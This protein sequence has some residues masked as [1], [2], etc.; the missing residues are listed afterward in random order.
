M[1][2]TKEPQPID[3]EACDEF[4]KDFIEKHTATGPWFRSA[5][6]QLSE[7]YLALKSERDKLQAFKDFVHRRLD[8][9]GV[10]AN[11]EPPKHALEGCRIGDRLDWIVEKVERCED[12]L[13]RTWAGTLEDR[14][15]A[16]HESSDEARAIAARRQ[17]KE[18]K[19]NG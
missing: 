13:V 16:A 2:P 1:K 19:A 8:T 7:A 15:V 18:G 9:A 5:K 17:D 3:W 14:V 4:A 10:P 12:L 11:P 6:V